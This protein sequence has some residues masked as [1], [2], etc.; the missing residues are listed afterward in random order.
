MEF[1]F[2]VRIF[3][4]DVSRFGENGTLLEDPGCVMRGG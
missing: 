1:D 4:P 3:L 2:T